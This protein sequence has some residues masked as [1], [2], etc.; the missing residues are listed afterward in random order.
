MGLLQF[1]NYMHNNLY[2]N[3]WPL[4]HA[5]LSFGTQAIYQYGVFVYILSAV[6]LSVDLV[7]AAIFIPIISPIVTRTE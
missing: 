1:V 2:R 7:L 3:D 4:Y 5:G 6:L